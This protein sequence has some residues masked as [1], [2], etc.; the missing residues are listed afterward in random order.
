[1][2]LAAAFFRFFENDSSGE[3]GRHIRS[4]Q[5]S[6]T[7]AIGSLSAQTRKQDETSL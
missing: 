1:M 4:E 3:N 5:K 2:A 7:L 6:Q